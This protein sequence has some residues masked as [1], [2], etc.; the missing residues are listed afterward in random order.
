MDDPLPVG[1]G[2]ALG[3]LVGVVDGLARRETPARKLRTQR[4][5][6]QQLLDD[7]GRPV[8]LADVVDDRDVGVVEDPG[9]TGFLLETLQPVRVLRAG[10][11]Q[12]LDSHIAAEPRIFAPVHLSHPTCA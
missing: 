2:Q 1:S 5:A 9:R 11:G 7:V 12:D 6:F 10:S 3:D 4:L 8:M